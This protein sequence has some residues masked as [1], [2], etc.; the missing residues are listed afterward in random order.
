MPIYMKA[1]RLPK[2]GSDDVVFG[3]VIGSN[4]KQQQEYDRG[5]Q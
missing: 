4:D 3:S 5:D 2:A 1:W